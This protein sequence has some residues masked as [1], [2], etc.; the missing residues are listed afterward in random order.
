LPLDLA[1]EALELLLATEQKKLL[2]GKKLPEKAVKGSLRD[3]L[4]VTISTLERSGAAD[5]K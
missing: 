1:K 2:P 5:N 4:N 3:R